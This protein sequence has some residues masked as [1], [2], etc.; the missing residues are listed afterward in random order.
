MPVAEP[1]PKKAKATPRP[2]TQRRLEN[3]AKF[4]IERFATTA[5]N[6]KR[7]LSRRSERAIRANGGDRQEC[8]AWIEAVVA[9]FVKA[10][11]VD[12]VRYAMDKAAS[13]RRLGKGPGKIRVLLAAKGVDRALVDLALEAGAV[14]ITGEDA[15]FEAAL[16]YARR[17][18]LGPFGKDIADH[19]EKRA[20]ATKD[21]AALG[22]AGFSYAIAKRIVSAASPE[23]IA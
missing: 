17:R 14:T 18:R 10:G 2:M 8:A 15:A 12:D 3:I 7:V 20:Q 22:R 6:L 19:K 11:L 9:R 1:T 23:D 13:L 21:M 16:A 5:A 4:H